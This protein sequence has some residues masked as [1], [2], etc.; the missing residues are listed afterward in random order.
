MDSLRQL[1]ASGNGQ[2]MA[3]DSL[4]KWTASG[5]G[6]PQAMG[7]LRQWA[8]NAHMQ[9]PSCDQKDPEGRRMR[10]C[11]SG[12]S[13]VSRSKKKARALPACTMHVHTC[14]SLPHAARAPLSR[15]RCKGLAEASCALRS[16]ASQVMQHPETVS[17][18]IWSSSRRNPSRSL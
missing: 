14:P 5:N 11:C 10:E 15:S 8:A 3:M 4:R 16:L 12:G 6:Q 17:T 18:P 7:S 13:V 1:T 2:P 9:P